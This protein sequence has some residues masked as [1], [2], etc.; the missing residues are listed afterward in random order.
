MCRAVSLGRK[1]W[2]LSGDRPTAESITPSSPSLPFLQEEDGSVGADSF[3]PRRWRNRP[4]GANWGAFGDEDQRGR[5]NLITPERRRTAAAEVREGIAFC[6]SLPL[7]HPGDLESEGRDGPPSFHPV[8][9]SGKVYFNFAMDRLD[10]SRTDVGCE[11]AVL[12]YPHHSTRWEALSHK[13]ALFDADGDGVPECIFYNGYPVVDPATGQGTQ[14]AL[15]ATALSAAVMA[16]TAVQG[17]GVLIDLHRHFGNERVVVGYEQLRR[18]M[19]TDDVMVEEGDILCL[20]TGMGR[21]LIRAGGRPDPTLRDACAVLDGHDPHL[22]KWITQSGVV[23]IATDN[24]GIENAT[25]LV[26]APGLRA[27][28]PALPLHEHCLFKL[29]IHIGELWFFTELADWLREHGRSRFLLTAPPLRLPGATSS[30]A[31]PIATV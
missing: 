20:R 22:L 25:P 12:I 21:L 30:P 18:I 15:G 4:P 26:I 5:L 19:Q 7:D 14:G 11:E 13:G 2:G 9:R 1:L 8:T 24:F 16:E 3:S 6:L 31:S 27:P 29:G 10:P 17:R 28:G 23:A